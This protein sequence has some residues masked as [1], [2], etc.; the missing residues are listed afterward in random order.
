MV[1]R[2]RFD[3]ECPVARSVDAIGD[4]W[5]LLIVRDA[6]D[7]SRRF[8]EFQRSAGV[9]KNILAA[10]LRT[11][12]TGG[13][14][15]SVPASDGS[16]YRE[17]VLTGKGKALFPVIV[18][19]R[20]C[21]SGASRTSSPPANRTRS[22]STAGRDTACAR[23]KCCPRTG[24]AWAPT[25]P[26]STS[27]PG[28]PGLTPR[29]EQ[30][31]PEPPV[32][33]V[34][35]MAGA[36]GRGAVA[37]SSAVERL[38]FGHEDAERDMAKGLLGPGFVRTAAY[39]AAV[40][41]RKMLIIGRKGSGKSAICM[42]LA[43]D[44]AHAGSTVMITPDD[45]AGDELRQFELHGLPGD[46]AKSLIWRYVFAVQA[47]RHL[48]DHARKAHGRRGRSAVRALHRFLRA[49]DEWTGNRLYDRL[50]NGARGLRTSLS[51]EAF[52]VRAAMDVARG[53]E[54]ARAARQL[55]VVEQGVAEAFGALGCAEAH[56][57]LLLLVDQLEQVWSSDL[58]S[59][60][61]L[62]GLLLAAKH[63]EGWYG[64][65][66][67]CLLF[68]RADIYDTLDFGEGDKFHGDELRIEWT[69][70]ALRELALARARA[71]VGAELSAE[72]L[73]TELFPREV[74]GEAS[75]G[76]LLARCL[77]RP[78]DVIQYLNLCRDTAVQAGHTSVT[79]QDVLHAGRQFSEWKVQ[80]LA[81]EYLVAHPYLGRLPVL[82]ENTGYVVTRGA[83]ESRL[84]AVT[85][86]LHGA[87]PEYAEA[88]TPAG[89]IETLYAVGFLGV[90]RGGE[91]EY[92]GGPQPGPQP[93]ETEF[94]IHPCFR[95][96][97]GCTR[98]TSLRSFRPG[99]LVQR[100][101]SGYGNRSQDGT[102]A[103]G[104]IGRDFAL[105]DQL[106]RSCHTVQRQV[107]R[108]SGLPDDTRLQ[109]I[110]QLTQVINHAS[111]ALLRL[112]GGTPVASGAQVLDAAGYLITL[113]AQ[114]RDSQVDEANGTDMVV[115]QLEVESSRLVR[116]VGGSTGGSG[117]SHN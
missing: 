66:L 85:S 103:A 87:F 113:A 53:S 76:H 32:P 22:W 104:V 20:H 98:P 80:D 64:R 52:G 83:L 14:L 108:A 55:E 68:L 67:R 106:I 78:R 50:V 28:D 15:E 39:E 79:E 102:Q 99:D 111:E 60:A 71:S 107:A 48:V 90:R 59:H 11:L 12:V 116:S 110:R 34:G 63:V 45:S 33:G 82:F 109:I 117:Q 93:H 77:P 9:A 38:Y 31:A 88:L 95:A 1:T 51:L 41:G 4:W 8:G 89:V 3:D 7:G 42:R 86:A 18:A 13:V 74:E 16:A 29:R 62:I 37:G 61:M 19:L 72:R 84:S 81:K 69:D 46:T 44:G 2:T 10:R 70:E 65:A 96:A 92:V 105:L 23:L 101:A 25:T 94:H 40:S 54:G 75:A 17:Y 30:P 114:L 35:I 56:A 115:R 91:V 26:P 21:G 100:V 24:D 58:D 49:N 27:S 47:A 6:F 5:S 97:L 57:P 36:R 112:R 73:W 43:A